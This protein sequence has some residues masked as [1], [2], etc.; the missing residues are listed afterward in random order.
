LGTHT[1]SIS[2]QKFEL[3]IGNSMAIGWLYDPRMYKVVEG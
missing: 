3:F 2:R 1:E